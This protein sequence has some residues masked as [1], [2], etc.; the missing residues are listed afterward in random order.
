MNKTIKLRNALI[1]LYKKVIGNELNYVSVLEGM[2]WIVYVK[3]EEAAITIAELCKQ[4]PN[5]GADIEEER[6]DIDVFNDKGEL[7]DIEEGE[8][9]GYRVVIT[10]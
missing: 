3:S 9:I 5:L 1:E 8:L 4:A 6:K 2:G 7:I 10:T